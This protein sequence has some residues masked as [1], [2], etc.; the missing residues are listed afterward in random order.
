MFKRKKGYL[1]LTML[2]LTGLAG[3][4][5]S[6]TLSGK[7]RRNLINELKTSRTAFLKSFQGL[8]KKQLRF[9]SNKHQL[10][11]EECV[12]RAAVFENALWSA[13]TIALQQSSHQ[14]Q[15]TEDSLLPTRFYKY[16]NNCSLYLHSG[17]K[18]DFQ[19]ALTLYNN[20]RDAAVRY[21]R[22][23]TENVRGHFMQTAWGKLDVYQLMLMISFSSNYFTRQ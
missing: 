22:T 6:D 18:Q 3:R 15:V 13:S 14:S 5:H 23:T 17:K 11:I 7:E 9:R 16:M 20:E 21:A 4:I 12:H 10:S 1:L 19:D 2:V 8:S